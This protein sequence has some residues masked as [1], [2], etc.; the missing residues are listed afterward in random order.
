LVVCGGVINSEERRERRGGQI[1]TERT[2]WGQR[3]TEKRRLRRGKKFLL[4][5]EEGGGRAGVA[6]VGTGLR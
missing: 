1:N 5:G 4:D 2:E 3:Y 6:V